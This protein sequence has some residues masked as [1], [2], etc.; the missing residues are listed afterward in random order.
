MV[1]DEQGG[2]SSSSD[3]DDDGNKVESGAAVQT[4]AM[5]VNE[6]KP[7]KPLKVTTVTGLEVT[8]DKLVELQQADETLKKYREMTTSSVA[9]NHKPHFLYKKGILYRHFQETSNSEARQQ[10]VVPESLREKVVSLAHDT[11]LTGHRSP[12]KTLSRVT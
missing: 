3:E 12:S 8:T 11:L 2:A 7:P 1:D 5:V 4:R 6:G 9:E 10:L